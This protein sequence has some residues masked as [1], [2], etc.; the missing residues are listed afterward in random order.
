MRALIFFIII[1][2]SCNE[3]SIQMLPGSS[4]NINTISVVIENELW[5]GNVGKEIRAHLEKPSY[6]LPQEEPLFDLKQMPPKIFSGFATKSRSIIKVEI[7][8]KEEVYFSSNDYAFP[9]RII[10]IQAKNNQSLISLIKKNS[11]LI[12]SYIYSGEISEKQRRIKK[13]KNSSNIFMNKFGLSLTFP[14]AYRV[15]KS[16]Q[17]FVWIRRDIQTGSVN[18]FVSRVSNFEDKNIIK[19]RDSLSK[20]HIPG[21]D[22]SISFMSTD[23]LYKT[24]TKKIKIDTILV[25]ETRGLWEAKGQFM[26][27]PFINYLINLQ[28]QK[29]ET[30]MLDGF[31]YSPGTRKRDYL[32]EIESIMRSI[33]I[34]D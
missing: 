11:D 10:Y 32:F 1:I 3:N 15:A 17:N 21:N 20:M 31:V 4:G 22:P 9:Q 2:F 6:G 30:Y 7:K 27:G 29:N 19:I 34:Q 24:V 16:N 28:P 13:S 5:E 25:H 33:K 26:A 8:E 14:S 12:R 18:L 23:T